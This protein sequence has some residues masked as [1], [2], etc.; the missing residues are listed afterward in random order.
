MQISDLTSPGGSGA[1]N[2][3][4]STHTPKVGSQIAICLFAPKIVPSIRMA[5]ELLRPA[6]VQLTAASVSFGIA[7]SI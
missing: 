4:I 3:P 6:Y 5:Y 7:Q 2:D 1:P